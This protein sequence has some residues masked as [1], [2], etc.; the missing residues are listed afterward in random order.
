MRKFALLTAAAALSL[1]GCTTGHTTVVHHR[2][3]VHVVHHHVV[4]H[5]HH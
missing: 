4:H 3:V 1:T 5:V 2:R